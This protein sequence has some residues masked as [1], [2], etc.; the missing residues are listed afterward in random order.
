MRRPQVSILVLLESPSPRRRRWRPPAT[1]SGFNPCSAGVPFSARR[2]G[3]GLAQPEA[4]FQSLF[5]W[6]PLLRGRRAGPAAPA[7]SGFNPCSAGVPF[8]AAGQDYW[9]TM[10]REVSILVLLESPSPPPAPVVGCAT[11][12]QVS[13]LVLLESPSPPVPA[14]S[15]TCA[16]WRFQSLFCCSPLLRSAI[17]RD[18]PEATTQFQSLFCW[19]PLLRAGGPGVHAVV[20]QV[21][22]LVLL[23]SPSPPAACPWQVCGQRGFNPCSAGVPFSACRCR[24][25]PGQWPGRVS[26]LVLLESPSPLLRLGAG[27]RA[28]ASKLGV[29]QDF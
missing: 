9:R 2:V 26:I 22:I 17:P 5:C 28:G 1:A 25:G 10:Q 16:A 29:C 11:W 21:S 4:G 19:S 14:R 20:A 23:E 8:S 15:G 18:S 3:V 7:W 6:S 13:I 24:A 12:T 27:C